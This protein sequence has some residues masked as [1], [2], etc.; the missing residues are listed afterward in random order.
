[1]TFV[2]GELRAASSDLSDAGVMTWA[3]LVRRL[4]R[5]QSLIAPEGAI[6]LHRPRRQSAASLL[7]VVEWQSAGWAEASSARWRWRWRWRWRLQLLNA[8]AHFDIAS[9]QSFA[10]AADQF[11]VRCAAPSGALRNPRSHAR[12]RTHARACMAARPYSAPRGLGDRFRITAQFASGDTLR[13]RPLNPKPYRP[14][15]PKPQT[16]DRDPDSP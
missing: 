15:P 8:H 6:R 16:L 14:R 4:V 3:A 13:C 7:G 2:R 12:E 5:K 10:G 9:L 11:H 1:V